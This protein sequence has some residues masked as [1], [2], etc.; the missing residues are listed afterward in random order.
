MLKLIDT[1]AHIDMIDGIDLA[2]KEAS[3]AGVIA[4]IALG[5]TYDSNQRVLEISQRH[6]NFVHAALQHRAA[7][8][9]IRIPDPS[10]VSRPTKKGGQVSLIIW[11]STKS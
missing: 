9:S 7:P 4:I 8:P 3:D 6:R 10:Q 1:H 5:Y 11:T 2:L